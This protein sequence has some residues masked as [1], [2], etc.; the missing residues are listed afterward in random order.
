[1]G[2]KLSKATLKIILN[3]IGEIGQITPIQLHNIER[4][5]TNEDS[6]PL[7]MKQKKFAR[8]TS[9]CRQTV[10]VWEEKGLIKPVVLP[11]GQKRYKFSD[12][13]KEEN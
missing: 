10:K 6:L 8:E 11:D 4:I 13:F 1:M 5:L 9:V 2:K 7:L 12:L 3:F